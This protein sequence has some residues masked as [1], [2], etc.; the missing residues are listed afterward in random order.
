MKNTSV[1]V[2]G[3]N[4][5]CSLGISNQEVWEAALS[6]K[7]PEPSLRSY[8]FPD[9]TRLEYP[10]FSL[11]DFELADC[12]EE[13]SVRW[14]AENHLLDD[15]DFCMLLLSIR[16]ALDDASFR[17]TGDS[18][19]GLVIGHENLGAVKLTDKFIGYQNGAPPNNQGD[20][21]PLFNEFRREF[22]NIQTFPYLFYL[23]QLLGVNGP[24][25]VVNNACA[26]GLYALE[27]GRMLI[28][29]G[30]ADLVIVA[31]SDYAHASEYLWLREKGFVSRQMKI[32]P[33]DLHRDG[34]IL[35]DGAGTLIL[36][37][38]EH[39]ARR[40]AEPMAVYRGGA[41]IQEH[42]H[43]TLP[44][45]SRHSY[46]SVITEAAGRGT[47]PEIDVIVP[48]GSGSTLWDR[49]EANEIHR[50]FGGLNRPVPAVTSFK[51]YFGH[52]LGASAMIETV[53]LLHCMKRELLLR[54][55]NYEQADPRVQLPVQTQTVHKKT[56]SALKSVPAYGGFHA[57]VLFDKPD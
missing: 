39:A 53:L 35:G 24:G 16:Q 31:C 2:T 32:R 1:L 7:V 28:A 34:S 44:D 10:V 51:G 4:M 13:K 43:M 37:S 17:I 41:F 25:Y 23:A 14:L 38:A 5:L 47:I 30:G 54:T 42:W 22:F 6:G 29:S 56:A 36:E 21:A 50:A 20:Q 12:L 40:S 15:R 3:T 26:S 19:I 9:G 45:V 48:H 11:P 49:Y 27:L 55:L 18:R 33:F 57:A 52:L 8:P 46:A